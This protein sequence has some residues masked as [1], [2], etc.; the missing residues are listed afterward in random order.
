MKKITLISIFIIPIIL[1]SFAF[2]KFKQSYEFYDHL[3]K[4]YD[5]YPFEE[6]N[7]D[8]DGDSKTDII[9]IVNDSKKEGV[10]NHRLKLF[11]QKEV[12]QKVLDIKYNATDGTLRTHI[13]FLVENN[14]RKIIIYDTINENQFFYWSGKKLE[15]S[16][17]PS[18]KEKQ[19][20]QALAYNDE[21]GG[22]YRKSFF[23]KGLAYPLFIG[24]LL[25]YLSLLTLLAL[26]YF[27]FT[28]YRNKSL[29]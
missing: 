25:I 7:F 18:F 26:V 10:Y 11:L 14:K 4:Q 19:I 9:K 24:S 17:N 27:Y 28:K 2:Y 5:C 23:T 13:A 15:I 12:P 16:N 29:P 1:L 22:F 3:G 20:R 21:T 8:V 6:C